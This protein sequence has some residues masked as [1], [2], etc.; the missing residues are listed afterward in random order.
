MKRIL[1][2]LIA[3][4]W[5]VNGLFFKILNLMPRHQEIVA[6]ILGSRHAFLLTKSIGAL[7]VLM[8]AWIVS[9]IKS[10]VCAITQIVVIL[11]MNII[12]FAMVPELLLFGK[13]NLVIAILFSGLI[14]FNEFTL[15]QR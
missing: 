7:E 12:E 10:R 3:L 8:F 4:V 15:K 13:L 14:C 2:M 11:L 9:G 1:N 5:L 6:E